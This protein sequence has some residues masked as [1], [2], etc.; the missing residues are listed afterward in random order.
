MSQK[1]LSYAEKL[2]ACSREALI[3]VCVLIFLVLI[4][5]ALGFGLAGA[6]ITLGGIPLWAITGTV[7][8]WIAAI[9]AATV[10]SR[11]FFQDFSLDDDEDGNASVSTNASA[12]DVSIDMDASAATVDQRE[13]CE[14]G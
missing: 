4:W 13:G 6:K 8:T 3:T 9:I 11:L 10:L 5:I 1:K 2:Q 12:A 7:G 14:R